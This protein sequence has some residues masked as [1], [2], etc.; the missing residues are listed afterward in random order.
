MSLWRKDSPD[1]MSDDGQAR[2]LMAFITRDN[3]PPITPAQIGRTWMSAMSDARI[4]WPNRCLPMLIAN[5]SGWELRN[6]CAFTATWM[7]QP[8]GPDGMI[9]PEKRA[10]GQ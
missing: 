2:P 1:L 6:P 7:G 8:G 4:G 9:A 10:P 3:A 5:Q